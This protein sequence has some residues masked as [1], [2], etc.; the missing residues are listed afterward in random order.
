MYCSL[1]SICPGCVLLLH[2]HQM[3]AG[4]FQSKVQVRLRG[5]STGP[6][7]KGQL[8]C[9]LG[10]RGHVGATQME[11]DLRGCCESHHPKKHAARL[12]LR[13]QDVSL[14]WGCV[15][16]SWAMRGSGCA[17]MMLRLTLKCPA[18]HRALC[19]LQTNVWQRIAPASFEGII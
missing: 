1:E 16:V 17:K 7:R 19:L 14:G 18:T 4:G 10:D 6:T 9:C 15:G 3:M 2:A 5:C 12:N 11:H 8:H 13:R